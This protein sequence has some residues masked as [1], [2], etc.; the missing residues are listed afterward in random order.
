MTPP[1]VRAESFG[2]RGEN[3]SKGLWRALSEAVAE[4]GLKKVL[5]TSYRDG[6]MPVDAL[7]NLADKYRDLVTDEYKFA[8]AIA[9]TD[10][11]HESIGEAVAK[12]HGINLRTFNNTN[13]ALEWL[14]ADGEDCGSPRRKAH[15]RNRGR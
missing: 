5:V 9:G 6:A 4:S 8:L 12:D 2:Q 3:A 15:G 10:Y 7:N 13:D 11:K 14:L 1:Y